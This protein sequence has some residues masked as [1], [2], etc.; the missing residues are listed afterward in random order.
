MKNIVFILFS[1]I[2]LS[3]DPQYDTIFIIKNTTTDTV[4]VIFHSAVNDSV[5]IK[6]NGEY[7]LLHDSGMSGGPS[8]LSLEENDSISI[9]KN[10]DRYIFYRDS[11]S[12]NQIY[13]MDNWTEN[14]PSKHKYKYIYIIDNELFK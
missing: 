1:I 8:K 9:I 7:I 14:N 13:I 4:N 11:S 3:C 10:D 6:P 5:Q 2:F 12:M